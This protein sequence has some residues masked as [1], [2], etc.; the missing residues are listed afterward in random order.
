MTLIITKSH[1]QEKVG[2]LCLDIDEMKKIVRVY[3]AD[4]TDPMGAS[5]HAE[6]KAIKKFMEVKHPRICHASNI[7]MGWAME[8]SIRI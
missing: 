4:K 1:T 5:S 8:S 3:P 2:R 7:Q 6:M